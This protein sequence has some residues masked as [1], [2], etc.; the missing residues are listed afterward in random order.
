MYVFYAHVLFSVSV[1]VLS[2]YVV[3][4]IL[5]HADM[6][7]AD[8]NI[9]SKEFDRHKKY[10]KNSC[11]SGETYAEQTKSIKYVL[12]PYNF[13]YHIRDTRRQYKIECARQLIINVL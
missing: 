9:A 3:P 1:Y 4:D 6:R 5:C 7:W 13:F 11:E 8:E 12:P 2:T 10:V